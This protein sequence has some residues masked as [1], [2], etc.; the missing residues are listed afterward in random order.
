MLPYHQGR[1]EHVIADMNKVG[2]TVKT[3]LYKQ[4][5]QEEQVLQRLELD[6]YLRIED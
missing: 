4:T 6:E 5:G 2:M 3:T 1:G